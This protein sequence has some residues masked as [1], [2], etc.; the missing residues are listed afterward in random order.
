LLMGF[1]DSC[2]EGSAANNAAPPANATTSNAMPVLFMI[3]LG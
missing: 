2:V 3:I 1:F